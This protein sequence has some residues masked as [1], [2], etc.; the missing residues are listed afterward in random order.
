MRQAQSR[1]HR[2]PLE[3]TPPSE[4]NAGTVTRVKLEIGSVATPF[5]RQ[6]LAKSMADCQRYFRRLPLSMQFVATVANQVMQTPMSF[7]AMRATPTISA[8]SADPNTTQSNINNA[9]NSISPQ[10]PY[11]CVPLL[12]ATAA[13]NTIIA[14]YRASAN[15]EL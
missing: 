3:P 1:Q 12:Q 8:I 13:G 10:S 6:S 11:G 9:G 15:A 7:A 2:C 14:G 5:N 4:F